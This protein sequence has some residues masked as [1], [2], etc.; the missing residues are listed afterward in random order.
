MYYILLVLAI[1][2]IDQYS[3]HLVVTKMSLYE[4]IP[5]IQD[6]FYLTSHRNR[7]AAFGILPNQQWLFITVTIGVVLFLI[8]YMRANYRQEPGAVW[9]FSLILGGAIGNLI[10]RIRTGEVV[11]FFHFIFGDFSFAIFNVADAAISVGVAFLILLTL[12]SKERNESVNPA[13]QSEES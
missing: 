10:D 11:D 4:S 7:G 12:F 9:A 2:G 6:F 3:K 13:I 8:Y 1:I 5:V